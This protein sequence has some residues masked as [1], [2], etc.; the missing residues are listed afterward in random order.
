MA[1]K[2]DRID[3][4]TNRAG[5][6]FTL[7]DLLAVVFRR[8]RL[9]AV[10]FLVILGGTAAT[11]L[12][13]PD[14]Y[15]AEMK[16]I[17]KRDR[18][19]PVISNR[20][21]A[22]VKTVTQ[23]TEQE[24]QSEVE[25]L[26]SYD[27]LE[28]VVIAAGLKAPAQSPSWASLLTPQ[29]AQAAAL[30]MP[31]PAP[32]SRYVGPA[33]SSA[34]RVLEKYLTVKTLPNTNMIVA[35]YES[36]DPREAVR[37]LEQLA[38][39]YMQKHLAVHRLP[40]TFNFFQRESERSQGELDQAQSELIAFRNKEGMAAPDIEKQITLQRLGE[41]E[42]A[43]RK[44]QADIR[45]TQE[46]MGVLESQLQQSSDRQVTEMR[47]SQSPH[48]ARLKAALSEL[49]IKRVELT[50]KYTPSY[51]LVQQLDKQMEQVRSEL[52]VEQS[53]PDVVETTNR[54]PNHEWL[55]S[56]LTKAKAELAGLTG[57]ATETSRAVEN[58]RAEARAMS[59][60]EIR[61]QNLMRAAKVAEENYVLY[62]Q[63]Q[64]EAR[65]SDLLDNQ[66]IVNVAVAE[67]VT[68]PSTPSSPSSS[69]VMV[70]GF[71]MASLVSVGLAFVWDRFDSTVR[72]PSEVERELGLPVL[73]SISK[74]R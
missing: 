19:E 21:T 53:K 6:S 72:V 3:K 16:F 42:A 17:V 13:E 28:K 46:R 12:L 73:A 23:V 60:V 29:G 44:T 51:R 45:D 56:E 31:V 74:V 62:R 52:A 22:G 54:D 41:S 63:R 10:T 69:S 20:E 43:L 70:L 39:L 65:I 32:D 4:S 57:R 35:R 9:I 14:S 38:E 25:L 55:R 15:E 49:E 71:L 8:S 58:Y 2:Q 11:A 30:D 37:V 34:V 33:L 66:R 26:E 18:V 27:L 36:R 40:G 59:E 7:R 50:E 47:T 1:E 24:L 48:V 5:G 61:E 67:S 68:L 64:E